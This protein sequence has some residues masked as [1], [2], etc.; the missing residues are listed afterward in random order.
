MEKEILL[1]I[2]IPSVPDGYSTI[3]GKPSPFI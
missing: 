2:H 1:S 3:L